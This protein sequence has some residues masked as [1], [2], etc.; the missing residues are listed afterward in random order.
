[1]HTLNTVPAVILING[2]RISIDG[3]KL[4]VTSAPILGKKDVTFY[5]EDE[6]GREKI[7]MVRRAEL[8]TIF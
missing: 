6:N 5:A 8:I 2:D 1:M 4:T 7:F 3:V